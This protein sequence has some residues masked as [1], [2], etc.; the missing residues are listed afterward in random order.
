M[1]GAGIPDRVRKRRYYYSTARKCQIGEKLQRCNHVI[2]R[3]KIMPTWRIYYTISHIIWRQYYY[4]ISIGN[5]VGIIYRDVAYY[6]RH[7]ILVSMC[8]HSR[9]YTRDKTFGNR[10]VT[11]SQLFDRIIKR[12]LNSYNIYTYNQLLLMLVFWLLYSVLYIVKL[13]QK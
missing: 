11:S 3:E 9:S 4:E 7:R 8:K 12:S 13:W 5:D 6:T 2:Y 10:F 1:T